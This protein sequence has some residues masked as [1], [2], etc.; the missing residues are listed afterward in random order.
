[1]R[2]KRDSD[3]SQKRL[4]QES[5]ETQTRLIRLQQDSKYYDK[6][7]TRLLRDWKRLEMKRNHITTE[8]DSNSLK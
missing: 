5:K 8:N 2:L 3:K 7:Q 1:M 6:T 4:R